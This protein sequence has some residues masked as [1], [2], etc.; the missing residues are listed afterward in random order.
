M[1]EHHVIVYIYFGQKARNL[2]TS[3]IIGL[4]KG[5]SNRQIV[6]EMLYVGCYLLPTVPTYCSIVLKI[7][8]FIANNTD[9][10]DRL[11]HWRDS[12]PVDLR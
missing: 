4:W 10:V 8:Q 11:N 2:M 12:N 1:N 3:K 7:L 5:S 6:M 9:D